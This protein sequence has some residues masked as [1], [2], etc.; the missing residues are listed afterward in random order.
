[1]QECYAQSIENMHEA[2]TFI[3]FDGPFLQSLYF[4][5]FTVMV[6]NTV[7]G[8]FIWHNP[9]LKN[10]HPYRLFS[11]ELL[12]ISMV[13]LNA[14]Q[15]VILIWLRPFRWTD[16]YWLPYLWGSWPDLSTAEE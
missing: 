7:L 6:F 13:F 15:Q 2:I 11:V 4:T 9:K 5:M 16:K 14:F 10:K 1:M 12:T 3:M 8:F